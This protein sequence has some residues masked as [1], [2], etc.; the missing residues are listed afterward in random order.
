MPMKRIPFAV[1]CAML[2]LSLAP[3]SA[4]TEIRLARQFSMGY[5]QFNVMEHAQLIEKHARAA[6]INDIKVSWATFNGP[7]AMNDALIS[8]NVDIVAGGVPGLLTLWNRTK[9]TANEVRGVS[10]LSSQ[11][12]LL[13]TRN[14]DVK[15]IA[16]LKD[17]DRIA[18]PAVKVSV[19][20]VMLQMAAAKQFG[21]TNFGK[22]DALTVSMSPPDATIAI[23]SGNNEVTAVFGVPPFQQQQLEKP[24]VRTILNS[25]DVMD[26]PHTFTVAWTSARFR[27]KN[28]A[29]YKAL[30]A[31]LKEAT[32]MVDN[33][34]RTAASYW[35]KDVNSKLPLD[36]VTEVVS[37]AQVKWTMTPQNAM[38]F[39]AFM[40][41]V[42][43]L[44]E[45]PKSWKDLFFP[46]IHDLNG[47]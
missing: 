34:R 35:I 18:V 3:A 39:A 27:D 22:F 41:S 29:L 11:P 20:A 30:I 8:G 13:N 42:G 24:G 6:G 1:I 2:A 46:E 38:K 10:A 47:S 33:D 26:G 28:P 25:F 21:Q 7:N 36:K 14:P 15:S 31:A 40:H 12:F 5:L 45:A 9:G 32:E 43:S 19:Q 23:M 44:K 17:S 37:G 4:E 16:D